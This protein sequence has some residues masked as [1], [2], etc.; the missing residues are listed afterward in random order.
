MPFSTRVLNIQR[1][2]N[3]AHAGPIV[4][5]GFWGKQTIKAV[6]RF[7]NFNDLTVDGIIGPKTL[8]KLEPYNI[9][10]ER[11]KPTLTPPWLPLAFQWLGFRETN[12]GIADFLRSD[13]ATVGDPAKIPWCGDFVQTVIALT[14]PN[15][16]LPVNPYWALNW[17]KFGQDARGYMLG[18]ICVFSRTGGGHVGFV[19]G[20][21]N[22][23]VH[24][25]GGN[26]SNSVS[27]TKV[28]KANLKALRW[29]AT[30]TLVG[31][32]ELPL[33]TLNATI[34]RSEDLV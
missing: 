33:S 29:P 22:T 11:I 10:S 21:D 18:A 25:L 6:R 17:I 3:S 16:I 32:M 24:V 7:Q 13:G 15:E 28:S 23:Y 8:A 26:Q 31:V 1:A 27:V 4:E 2:L 19:M 14:L 20:H 30:Q 34:S 12:K 9:H 5:D